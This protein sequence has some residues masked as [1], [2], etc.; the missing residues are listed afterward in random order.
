M[1]RPGILYV[2]FWALFLCT[3]GNL[4]AQFT[5]SGTISD[6]RT[7]AALPFSNLLIQGTIKGAVSDIDG[8]FTLEIEGNQEVALIVSSIGYLTQTVK[9]SPSNNTLDIQLREDATNL[10]EVIVTGLA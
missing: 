7:K 8:K 5:V 3:S 2:W 10:E 1:K 6:A 4:M 9:A